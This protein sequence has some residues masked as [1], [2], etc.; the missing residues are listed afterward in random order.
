M[1]IA[2]SVPDAVS[3]ENLQQGLLLLAIALIPLVLVG[4]AFVLLMTFAYHLCDELEKA[5]HDTSRSAFGGTQR[6]DFQWLRTAIVRIGPWLGAG[7]IYGTYTW[8]GNTRYAQWSEKLESA[9]AEPTKTLLGLSLIAFG[10]TAYALYNIRHAPLQMPSAVR[11]WHDLY[12]STDPICNG[13]L[14]GAQRVSVPELA[15]LREHS[16]SST[17]LFTTTR[18]YNYRAPIRD[19]IGYWRNREQ[20]VA[21]VAHLILPAYWVSRNVLTQG[22]QLRRRAGHACLFVR[23]LVLAFV[24]W[25][26]AQLQFYSLQDLPAWITV[27]DLTLPA[28]TVGWIM[29]I[30]GAVV[31]SITAEALLGWALRSGYDPGMSQDRAE[32]LAETAAY[33]EARDDSGDRSSDMIGDETS[34]EISNEND[35]KYSNEAGNLVE[36][37]TADEYRPPSVTRKST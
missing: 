29:A 31:V 15:E 2:L 37:K 25:A 21:A 33:E 24:P 12:A 27:P 14:P 17:P 30:A 20:F 5:A 11:H 16:D 35:N 34:N 4:L 1:W 19:H 18:V 26:G 8:L 36:S 10:Y 6:S 7:M 28:G 13:P 23:L 3:I 22:D 32:Y 9:V